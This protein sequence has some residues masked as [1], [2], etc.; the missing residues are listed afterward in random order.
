MVGPKPKPVRPLTASKSGFEKPTE[1]KTSKKKKSLKAEPAP[2]KN[3]KKKQDNKK[4][5]S[6]SLNDSSKTE[7]KSDKT[8]Y[9]QT[10]KVFMAL[11][12]EIVLFTHI[13]LRRRSR[14]C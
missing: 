9:L 13:R 5:I 12:T 2:D 14:H 4:D 7:I 3:H 6:G 10:G 8:V 1:N 11:S